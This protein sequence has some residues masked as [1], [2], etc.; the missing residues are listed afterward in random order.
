RPGGGPGRLACAPCGRPAPGRLRLPGLPRGGL[1]LLRLG[2]ARPG[3]GTGRRLW[4]NSFLSFARNLHDRR[5]GG[6]LD[7]AQQEIALGAAQKASF[8]KPLEDLLGELVHLGLAA[9]HA[10]VGVEGRLVGELYADDVVEDA[11]QRPLVDLFRIPLLQDLE[12]AVDED[13]RTATD[14][15]TD[16]VAHLPDRA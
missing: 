16:L 15:P 7:P 8:E 14:A 6:G 12:G 10:D 3:L 2:F 5:R 4:G 13:L 11:L 9:V 1:P